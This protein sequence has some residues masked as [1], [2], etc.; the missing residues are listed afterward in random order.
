MAFFG[1]LLS[2]AVPPVDFNEIYSGGIVEHLAA[3]FSVTRFFI[4]G[5]AVSEHRCLPE[6]SGWTVS[7][8][9]V[10]FDRNNTLMFFER[11]GYAHHDPNATL[12]SCN[13][14]YWGVLPSV[15]VGITIRYAAFLAMVRRLLERSTDKGL[16]SCI[17]IL[18]SFFSYAAHVRPSQANKET[19]TV[20]NQEESKSRH[21]HSN[22]GVYHGCAHWCNILALHS[23]YQSRISIR[24]SQC[25]DRARK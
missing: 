20:R 18:L 11:F 13:G 23:R 14:F 9:S 6:Q 1:L 10:N 22:L 8:Y 3:W 19:S 16:R 4:E 25:L 5:L 17:L 2:G 12:V 7:E 15:F 21:R 24:W